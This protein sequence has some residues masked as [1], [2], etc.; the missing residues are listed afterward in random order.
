MKHEDYEERLKTVES[1]L[2]EHENNRLTNRDDDNEATII[3]RN[4]PYRMMD[5]ADG[6][7]LHGEGLGLDIPV[8]SVLRARSV[9]HQAGVELT[10]V[11]DKQTV[12]AY[13]M[14]LSRT[15]KYYDV[16]ID[17]GKTNVN[18]RIEQKF[19]M[20]VNN[21]RGRR[22][23]SYAMA[24]A[25]GLITIATDID[26]DEQMTQ[27]TM[28]VI[29]LITKMMNITKQRNTELHKSNI[30][31]CLWNINGLGKW[32]QNHKELTD[33]MNSS[34]IV[35]LVETWLANMECELIKQTCC[36]EVHTIYSC[37]KMNKKAKRN[38]GGILIFLKKKDIDSFIS[39]VQ[40]SDEDIIWLK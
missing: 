18:R 2:K 1:K 3:V 4:L 13:K 8:Q 15:Q 31:V 35:L 40:H 26:N 23:D 22:P 11:R 37:R 39:V 24:A 38:S 28:N 6:Q 19:K 34:E 10:C 14:K 27:S 29:R 5:D 9:N 7:Q 17:G 30:R 32:K 36:N 21:L 16:F 20:L 12:I 25:I 33:I